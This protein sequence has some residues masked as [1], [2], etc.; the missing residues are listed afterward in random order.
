[1]YVYDVFQLKNF[2][3]ANAHRFIRYSEAKRISIRK[4]RISGNLMS[5]F[6]A[7]PTASPASLQ[8]QSSCGHHFGV[9]D[10]SKL[11]IRGLGD[12]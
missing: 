12:L 4:L 10:N 8:P 1:M 2:T 11:K 5:D 6:R 7:L 9:T 3:Q